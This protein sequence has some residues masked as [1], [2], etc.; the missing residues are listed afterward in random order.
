[1]L[2]EI[3]ESIISGRRPDEEMARLYNIS[4]LTLAGIVVQHQSGHI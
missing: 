4:K 2:R 1:M 3:A